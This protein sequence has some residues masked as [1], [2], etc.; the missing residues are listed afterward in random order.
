MVKSSKAMSSMS[1]LEVE[2]TM[3]CMIVEIDR[4]WLHAELFSDAELDSGK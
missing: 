3:D 2:I 1:N 4:P